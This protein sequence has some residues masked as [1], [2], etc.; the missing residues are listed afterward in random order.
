MAERTDYDSPWKTIIEQHLADCLAF[1]FP[2]LHVAID[3]TID[4]I[5]REQE[6]QQIAVDSDIGTR[7]V[8]KLVDVQLKSGEQVWL[9]IHIEV[10]RRSESD[11]AERMFVYY[12]RIFEKFQRHPVSLAILTDRSDKWRPQKFEKAQFGCKVRLDFPIAKLVDYSEPSLLASTNPF[13]L[14]TLAQQLEN[15]TANIDADKYATKLRLMR[16]LFEQGYDKSAIRNLFTFIDWI[17]QL[18]A[19]L[20]QHLQLRLAESDMEND[21]Q[22]VSYLERTAEARGREEGLE[23][24][25]EVAIQTVLTSRLGS[26]PD[27]LMEKVRQLNEVQLRD[28]LAFVSVARTLDDVTAQLASSI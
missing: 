14:V 2:T 21:M 3:W 24:G 13:A 12:Y 25:L 10:Q 5:F 19:E 26:A 20:E 23:Q 17:L 6:L 4:P 7:R 28:L 22:Y 18:P 27:E 11:F 8:D 15:V 1:Y 16:L 9:L